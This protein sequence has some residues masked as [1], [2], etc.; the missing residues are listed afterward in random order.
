[1]I[2][3]INQNERSLFRKIIELLHNILLSLDFGMRAV[4]YKVSSFQYYGANAW[5]L[6]NSAGVWALVLYRNV[7]NL[8][9]YSRYEPGEI[10]NNAKHWKISYFAYIMRNNKYELLQLIGNSSYVRTRENTYL[11]VYFHQWRGLILPKAFRS[12][13]NKMM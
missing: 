6:T 7:E 9:H 8:V 3:G 1:M 2:S 4:K 5:T 10:S 11:M 12:A 13:D